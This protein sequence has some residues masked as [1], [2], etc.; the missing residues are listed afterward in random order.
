LYCGL[1][2]YFSASLFSEKGW[3][4]LAKV[5]MLLGVVAKL[6]DVVII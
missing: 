4:F 6:N 5:F 1:Y 3:Q 2:K